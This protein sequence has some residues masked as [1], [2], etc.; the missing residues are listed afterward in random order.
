MKFVI[1]MNL[2][3]F[4][5]KEFEEAGW[6]AFHWSTIGSAD[7]PDHEIMRWAIENECVVFTHNLDF[8]AILAATKAKSP[9]LHLCHGKILDFGLRVL[10]SAARLVVGLMRRRLA[11]PFYLTHTSALTSTSPPNESF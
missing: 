11:R 10:L 1:D 3:P 7:A 6:E 5:V 4:W 8:G 2:S 9:K